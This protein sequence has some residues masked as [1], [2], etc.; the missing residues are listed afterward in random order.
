MMIRTFLLASTTLVLC[1]A[2]AHAA[3]AVVA[4]EPEAMN[5]VRVCDA[6]GDG[7]FYIPGTETCLKIGGYVRS[8]HNIAESPYSGEDQGWSPFTRGTITLDAR[9][10]T[11][12]GLLRSF[13]ELRAEH[14]DE[15]DRSYINSAYI[16]LGGLRAGYSDSRYDTWLNS[17]GN[18]I[19]DDVIDYTGDRTNQLSYVWGGEKGPSA[20]IGLEEGA[21]DYETGFPGEPIVEIP[22]HERA[23]FPIAGA[24]IQQDWG[25]LFIIG[26]YDT[27][28]EAFGGK[29][30]ADYV[31]ND[32]FKIF[33][34]A[35]WQSDW[36]NEKGPGDSRRRN[37]FGPWNGDWAVWGGFTATVNEKTSVN[38]QIAWE[39][40]GTLATALNVEYQ[41]V[42]NF[43]IQPEFNYTKFDGLRGN[44]DSFGG[45]IRFQ[46]DF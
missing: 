32:V 34:M 22:S 24:R 11:E 31:F 8:D 26:G 18:I 15:A 4:A 36:D 6:Y 27:D 41:M 29:I 14:A 7:F 1:T 46:R 2:G 44:D 30:R 38:G 40:D 13:I 10:D 45:T 37:Y 12:Y 17:A 28:A 39:D 43:K 21:G 19:N 16:E 33:A 5:Y 42:E 3:D 35:G 23:P 20:F 25:G 9:S